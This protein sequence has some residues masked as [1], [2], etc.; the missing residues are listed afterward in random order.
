MSLQRMQKILTISLFSQSCFILDFGYSLLLDLNIA[1]PDIP[2]ATCILRWEF[3]KTVDILGS[4][5]MS[6]ARI[7]LGQEK[8]LGPSSTGVSL[9]FRIKMAPVVLC[10]TWTRLSSHFLVWSLWV[11]R[12]IPRMLPALTSPQLPTHRQR[13]SELWQQRMQTPWQTSR[14]RSPGNS[15]RTGKMLRHQMCLDS[16]WDCKWI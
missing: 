1:K 14:R 3:F 11:L 5:S 9:C 6:S 7:G 8:S 4:D 13:I 10:Y 2:L 15:P 16:P 12:N